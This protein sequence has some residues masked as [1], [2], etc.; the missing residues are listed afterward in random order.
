MG[1]NR[2][3]DAE[4][5][6]QHGRLSAVVTETDGI[7]VVALAGEIDHHTADT[8]REA[9]DAAGEPRPRVVADMGQVTFMDSSGI[10]VLIT[11]HGA[12]GEAG[13]WLRLAA[14]TGTVKRTLNIVGVDAFIDCR[15]SLSHA[16]DD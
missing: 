13:G 2:M 16:L 6:A 14:P 11:A 5:A 4:H 3:A 10:N 7:R 15:E 9:L 12:L 1:E 8:L